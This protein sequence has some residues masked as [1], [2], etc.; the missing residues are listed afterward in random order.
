MKS[1]LMLVFVVVSLLVELIRGRKKLQRSIT[2][3]AP[4]PKKE[5]TSLDFNTGLGS[6]R[7]PE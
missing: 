2:R 7:S 1:I 5:G 6:N 4:V 3:T